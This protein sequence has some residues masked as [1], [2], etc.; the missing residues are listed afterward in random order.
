MALDLEK[1]VVRF[2]AVIAVA[3][4]FLII[5]F[6]VYR[7]VIAEGGDVFQAAWFI[8]AAI[9][10]LLGALVLDPGRVGKALRTAGEVASELAPFLRR[11]PGGVV[12][13]TPGTRAGEPG[14]APPAAPDVLPAPI[15]VVPA[16]PPT[17]PTPA[18]EEPRHG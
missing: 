12:E 17:P 10:I 18:L 11:G 6:E 16:V 5:G 3:I 7:H 13:I 9:L 2:A 15:V 14:A 8:A 1:R 4:G